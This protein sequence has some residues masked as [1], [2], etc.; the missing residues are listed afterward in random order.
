MQLGGSS[1]P[2]TQKSM[3][4][5]ET[6][7]FTFLAGEIDNFSDEEEVAIEAG[8][9]LLPLSEAPTQPNSNNGTPYESC[10]LDVSELRIRHPFSLRLIG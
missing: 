3:V 4:S 2:T 7:A 9:L 1:R 8:F 10:G 5:F 6:I